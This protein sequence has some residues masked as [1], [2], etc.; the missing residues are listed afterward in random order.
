MFIRALRAHL[1]GGYRL[2]QQ[3]ESREFGIF[4]Y[5]FRG[6]SEIAPDQTDLL[7]LD[8]SPADGDRHSL[9]AITGVQL[10]HYVLDVNLDGLF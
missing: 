4:S 6:I 10:L 7:Q 3:I 1:C 8:D 2:R 9:R 5:H